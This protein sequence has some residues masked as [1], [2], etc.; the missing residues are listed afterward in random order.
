[1]AKR[2][3]VLSSRSHLATT[4][5]SLFAFLAL[6]MMSALGGCGGDD[7]PPTVTVSPRD[8]ALAKGRTSTVNVR[9]DGEAGPSDVSWSSADPAIATVVKGTR[10]A[11]TIT[12]TGVGQT[13]VTVAYKG[14][15][16]TVN[17]NVTAAVVTSIGITPAMPSLAVGTEED[18][19][20]TATLSDGTTSNVTSMVEWSSSDTSKATV[21]AAGRWRGV[22]TGT[23]VLTAKLG[24][25]TATVNVSI[26]AAVLRTIAIT[27]AA[28]S[29]AKGRTQQMTATGTF[30]DNSTQNLTTMATWASSNAGN[31]SIVATG[32]NAGLLTGAGAGTANITATLNGITGQVAVTITN[33]VLVSVAVTPVDRQ[34][35]KGLTL[36]FTA[37]GTYSDAT[38][39]DLSA[40]A[41]WAS[42]DTGVASMNGRVATAVT[43]GD[44]VISATQ[45]GIAGQTDLQVTAAVLASIA[46]APATASIAKG[47][48]QQLVATGTLTDGT[49]QDL[50]QTATWSSS[51]TALVSVS[52][53]AGSQGLA[54][55]LNVGTATIT[56]VQS[57][58]TGTATLEVTAAE[59]V[60][61]TVEPDVTSLPEGRTRQLVAFG[62]FSDN[63]TDDITDDADWSSSDA[64]IATVSTDAAPRG[65]VTGVSAGTATIT[66]A[67][68]GLT[69][70]TSLTVTDAILVTLAVT[71]ATAAV[72]EGLT[73]QYTATGTFSDASTEDLTDQVTWASSDAEV[74]EISNA[75]GSRGLATARDL[76]TAT[77]TAALSGV[78]GT[79]ELEATAAVY[80]SISL[81]PAVGE[82]PVG[83]TLQF[84]ATGHLSNGD[85]DVITEQATW[86]SSNLTFATVSNLAG[87]RGLV[88][89]LAVGAV[90]ITASF[91]GFTASAGLE[92]VDPV[93]ES[94]ALDVVGD[95]MQGTS[96]QLVAMGTFSDGSVSN[97]TA[98][99]SWT[100]SDPAALTVDDAA[101]KGRATA[102]TT[103]GATVTAALDDV[104]ATVTIAGC[105]LLV[106]EVQTVG[107]GGNNDEFVEVLSTC[108]TT[109]NLTGL[110][111]V[112]RAAGGTSDN[113][114]ATLSTSI[115]PGQH[116]FWVNTAVGDSYTGEVGTFGTS[117]SAN[118]GGVGVMRVL[119]STTIIDS[120]GFGTATNAFIEGTR[121]GAHVSGQSIARSPD[122]ADTN[123]NSADFVVTG[124]RTPGAA[125]PAPPPPVAN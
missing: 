28:L 75:A 32:A 46:I 97:V 93:I 51:D 82:L 121:I 6:G 50:T 52:N 69:D 94:I 100:S 45:D 34:L 58:V 17:V 71:P 27:P 77:I 98:L 8:V 43:E 103:A 62:T 26:T 110:R 24:A 72:P 18:L 87:T 35:A 89:G 7:G 56:A 91:S 96:K 114:I 86:T 38:T 59:L 12:A 70:S 105:K 21:T 99:L 15:R 16:A 44:T 120:M 117:M 57:G 49:T 101:N 39:A 42:S 36:Q 19:T 31:A 68:N 54:S 112:Y 20:A 124:N 88:S 47:R 33:A 61:I 5:L 123:D 22:A 9:V 107:P 113:G 73:Q 55:A 65:L 30:S 40:T 76:G 79:A 90:T 67:M 23:A 4:F 115:E 3:C 74:A 104:S 118:G 14:V 48:T 109:Q 66:A 84:N 83:R 125:N 53:A 11:A 122:G 78:T 29:L 60:S 102:L 81:S 85:A 111:L 37:T 80:T 95:L 1:M 10:G 116:L 64:A 13:Q 108:A 92:V 106:N 2:G 41:A 25:V 63:T 119:P